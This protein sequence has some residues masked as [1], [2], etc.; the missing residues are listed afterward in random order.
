[1]RANRMLRFAEIWYFIEVVTDSCSMY[2][3]LSQ[4]LFLGCHG[5]AVMGWDVLYF[6][7]TYALNI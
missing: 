1:M 7:I 2:L 4:C 5:I 6:L 3:Y